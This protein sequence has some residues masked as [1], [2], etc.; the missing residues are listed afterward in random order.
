MLGTWRTFAGENNI[1]ANGTAVHVT[2]DSC[3][4]KHNGGKRTIVLH[5]TRAIICRIT[6]AMVGVVCAEMGHWLINHREE[7]MTIVASAMADT[8]WIRQ[9]IHVSCMLPVVKTEW[10]CLY[11][12]RGKLTCIV[13]VAMPVTSCMVVYAKAG[14]VLV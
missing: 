6:G 13:S 9:H 3:I 7:D 4:R 11:K 14:M 2:M 1:V 12:H 8:M 10:R 5:A